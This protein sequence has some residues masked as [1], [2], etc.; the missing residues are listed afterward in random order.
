MPT[1]PPSEEPRLFG[2]FQL[3]RELGRGAQ[4]IVWL[5]EDTVLRRHVALKMLSNAG[6]Q[7][8]LIRERFRREAEVASRL[9]HPGI[10]GVHAVGEVDGVPYIAMQFV[11]GQTLADLLDKARATDSSASDAAP[12]NDSTITSLTGKDAI[13]D[14]L[15]LIERAARALHAAHEA[16]LVHRDIKPA[17]LMITPEGHP[18]ILDFGLARDLE[19]VDS[20][21]TETGAILGTPAYMAAEQLRGRRDEIDRRTDVYALGVTLFE[22]LTL[23]R[24]FEAESFEQ[25]YQ[26]ILNGTPLSPRKLNPRI[27]PDLGTVVEVAIERD[28]ARRYA[29]A[30]ELA[31]DLRRVRAFEPIRA[32]APGPWARAVKWA[33]RHP[34]LAVAGGALTLF[35]LIGLG[36]LVRADLEQRRAT[37]E[38]LANA[39]QALAASEFASALESVAKA[40]ERDPDSARAVELK[41]EIERAR[42]RAALEAQRSADLAAAREACATARERTAQHEADR[43]RLAEL[44]ADLEAE[45]TQVF[46]QF[47]P[48]VARAAFAE[49]E[50]EAL[51]LESSA[52]R[53]VSEAGEALNAAARLEARWGATPETE[54]AFADHWFLLWSEALERGQRDE[55]E[56]LQGLVTLHDH[57]Q[58]YAARLLGHGTLT[59]G[60][61]PF[62]TELYLFRYESLELVDDPAAVPRL[63]PVPS[64]GLARTPRLARRD[65]ATWDPCLRVTRVDAGGWAERNGLTPGVHLE[66]VDGERGRKGRDRLRARALDEPLELLCCGDGPAPTLALPAGEP[67]GFTVEVTAAPLFRSPA[68]R[69]ARGETRELAPGSY[70]VL[71][72]APGYLDQRVPVLVPRLGTV[73][74]DVTLL[75]PEQVPVG[76]EY[77]PGGSFIAGGDPEAPESLSRAEV[78]LGPFFLARRELTNAEWQRFLDDPEVSARIAASDVPLY[79]PREPRNGPMAAEVL[80]GPDAPVMGVSWNDV[81]DYLAW[82][83]AAAERDGE[84]FVYDLPTEL[85]WEKAARGVDGR[86][87][88]FG[89]RFDFALVVGFHSRERYL[90]DAP[91]GLEPRDE[92][93]YGMLDMT[94]HR[95]EWTRDPGAIEDPSAPPLYRYRGGGWRSLRPYQYRAAARG[96]V[97]ASFTSG[98]LGFRLAA[99]PREDAPDDADQ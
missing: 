91:G 5:A 85:E 20:N 62:E 44:R 89:D 4:G 22:A 47:A 26:L 24:P 65:A 63:V 25:F 9:E 66:A 67:A 77:V 75:R 32:K 45:R 70:V 27:P 80:G 59:L 87:F 12:E 49:K 81:H 60:A 17:N 82:R 51:R 79:V 46:D 74:L 23:R 7:S 48:E 78:E 53:T 39:E 43:A 41:A 64:D 72:H 34:T 68:N 11:R 73:R 94:A 92:S 15:R 88:A 69:L 52:Q 84:A 95:R 10:C 1:D 42:D 3:L 6:L 90:Y 56:R 86:A 36:L 29:S 31:E 38:H 83:N 37:R 57:E 2:H 76:F 61:V 93:P 99:R 50:R 33:K 21:L 19:D 16:G 28:R 55:A 13:S 98:D 14:V 8:E 30:L 35:T 97:E 58:R 18:V 96:M 71:A 40:R 54:R